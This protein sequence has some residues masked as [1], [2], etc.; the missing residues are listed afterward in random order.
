MEDL[1]VQLLRDPSVDLQETHGWLILGTVAQS[2]A[3]RD[4]AGMSTYVKL[5]DPHQCDE[6][7]VKRYEEAERAAHV[8]HTLL[9]DG[10]VGL[11][12]GGERSLLRWQAAAGGTLHAL[13]VSATLWWP[14]R[15]ALSSQTAKVQSRRQ[16][17]SSTAELK[18]IKIN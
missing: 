4:V 18:K 3:V 16:T 11:D 12:P 9:A 2:R 15:T 14:T 17:L 8:R 10:L 13:T 7:E 5:N 1:C 6:E